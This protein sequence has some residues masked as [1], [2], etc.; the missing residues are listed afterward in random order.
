M[1]DTMRKPWLRYGCACLLVAGAMTGAACIQGAYA[2][3]P[4]N[5][6]A[7]VQELHYMAPVSDKTVVGTTG[8][9]EENGVLLPEVKLLADGRL[10]QLTPS[11]N[12]VF[13]AEGRV[14]SSYVNPGF[15][16]EWLK[17]DE[18]GCLSCHDD[19]AVLVDNFS[20]YPHLLVGSGVDTPLGYSQCTI[21]HYDAPGLAGMGT[22][23]HA[24]H[25]GIADCFDCHASADPDGSMPVW[26]LGKYDELKGISSVS[27]LEGEFTWEQDTLT[28][29]D[30]IFN[31]GWMGGEG[32]RIRFDDT[33]ETIPVDQETFDTWAITVTGAVENEVSWSLPELI[34]QAPSVTTVM[35]MHCDINPLG[36]SMI[37]QAQITGI[38][39][40]W[41]L[42]QA[43]LTDEAQT[44]R[45][46]D[47]EGGGTGDS[48]A[49]N[50]HTL[51][52]H[53]TLIVYEINGEPLRWEHG[54]PVQVWVGEDFAARF[55][56]QLAEIRVDTNA[57]LDETPQAMG[58]AQGL[59]KPNVGIVGVVEGQCFQAGEP[60]TFEGY[61][62]AFEQHISAVEF[63]MDGGNTWQTC[64]TPGSD[65]SRWVYWHF[66][67]TPPADRNAAYHLQLRAKTVE[68]RT[69]PVP[70]DY[71]FNTKADLAQFTADVM[72]QIESE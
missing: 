69:T 6:D 39:V 66:T 50:L 36:G 28:P 11:M 19:L 14:D 51:S 8:A 42:E 33:H 16:T 7:Q 64:Y 35:K 61:A 29:T 71:M 24:V 72:A 1:F 4:A 26:D 30:D 17:A 62:D 46:I 22:M 68:G 21:C 5:Q 63:S 23:I 53:E 31:A 25:N 52:E 44:V 18:R 27:N 59:D 67:W 12:G 48:G 37:G 32:A 49:L 57:V 20:S 70:L 13:D 43:G 34:E 9:W 56:K 3:E 54:Y 2:D 65:A 58:H 55:R 38:P 40:S 60:I 41:L 45:F 15:N 47:N 10:V